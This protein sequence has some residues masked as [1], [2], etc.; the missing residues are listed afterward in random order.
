MKLYRK[1]IS[2][3]IVPTDGSTNISSEHKWYPEE[4]KDSIKEQYKEQYK[5]KTIIFAVRYV[6]V[7][8]EQDGETI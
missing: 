3:M 8:G 7:K 1:E 6:E 4:E 5:D 2:P